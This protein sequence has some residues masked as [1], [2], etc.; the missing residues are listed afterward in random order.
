M[1]NKEWD[2]VDKKCHYCNS[3]I[4][5]AKGINKQNIKKL[6]W[7]KPTMQDIIIFIMLVLCLTMVWA[8]YSETAQYKSMFE[9]PEEFCNSY[10][11]QTPIKGTPYNVEINISRYNEKK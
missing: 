2:A 7:S 3:T 5:Q 11:S 1:V 8:Y 10:W 9:D 6:C 4:K